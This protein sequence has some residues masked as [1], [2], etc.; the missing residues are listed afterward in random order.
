VWGDIPQPGRGPSSRNGGVPHVV[1]YPDVHAIKLDL[2]MVSQ[3]GTLLVDD[4]QC[5]GEGSSTSVYAA[6]MALCG[7]G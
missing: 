5:T 7:T 4:M 2:I 1:L 3:N 6:Q